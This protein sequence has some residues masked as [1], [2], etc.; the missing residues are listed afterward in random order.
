MS[1]SVLIRNEVEPAWLDELA[2]D[3]SAEAPPAETHT[4]ERLILS[5]AAHHALR[6]ML[7]DQAGDVTLRHLAMNG[8]VMLHPGDSPGTV[9]VTVTMNDDAGPRGAP[10][11]ALEAEVRRS[12]LQSVCG[13]YLD[14]PECVE[15]IVHALATIA[16]LPNQTTVEFHVGGARPYPAPANESTAASGKVVAFNPRPVATETVT[17]TRPGP[18]PM[19]LPLR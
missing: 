3:E 14:T 2:L 15:K 8:R 7:P 18:L 16:G 5:A 1:I 4:A 9:R 11:L 13:D 12:W 6:E 19:P 17:V 10:G